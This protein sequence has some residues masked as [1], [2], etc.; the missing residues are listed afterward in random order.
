MRDH[1][2]ADIRENSPI[3]VN[4]SGGYFRAAYVDPDVKRFAHL[5]ARPRYTVTLTVRPRSAHRVEQDVE[6]TDGSNDQCLVDTLSPTGFALRHRRIVSAINPQG[7]MANDVR[8]HCAAHNGHVQYAGAVAGKRSEFGNPA[9]EDTR[10]HDRVKETNEQNAPHRKM[11][12]AEYGY[13]YQQ[14]SRSTSQSKHVTRLDS[15]TPR[16]KRQK[17]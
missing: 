14:S 7:D 10:K 15:N 13:H 4:Q 11:S 12:C 6:I 3:H 17:G 9:G 8:D 5:R 1:R 16:S 2:H